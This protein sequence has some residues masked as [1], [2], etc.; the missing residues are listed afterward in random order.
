MF[1]T[2]LIAVVVSLAASGPAAGSHSGVQQPPKAG[3]AAAT[4]QPI[5][6]ALRVD[7]SVKSPT[8]LVEV[9]PKYTTEAMRARI[10]GIVA[11]EA[12]VLRDGTVGEVKVVRSLDRKFGLD[13]QAVKAVN[14]WR[15]APGTKEGIAVPVLVNVELTFSLRK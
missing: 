7:A 3:V 2:F 10:E 15:F 4:P 8:V 5:R 9:K 12:V 13:D 6:P 1:G 14:Q 11:V